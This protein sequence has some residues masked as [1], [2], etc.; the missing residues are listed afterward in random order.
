MNIDHI[1]VTI[2]AGSHANQ[3][4]WW[5]RALGR[6]FDRVP[7]PSCREWDLSSSVIFQVIEGASESGK[8]EVA[9]HVYDVDKERGRLAASGIQLE[10]PQLVPGFSALRWAQVK[11]PEGNRLSLLSGQ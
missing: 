10:E 9:L 1:Y 8:T 3:I 5:T 11:D 2:M 4:D 6:T 7:V